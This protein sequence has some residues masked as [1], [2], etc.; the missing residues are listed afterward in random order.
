M[1]LESFYDFY[2]IDQVKIV[3][4]FKYENYISNNTIQTKLY[5]LHKIQKHHPQT[6]FT[7]LINFFKTI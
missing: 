4:N 7:H 5:K 1:N 3:K 2:I 6:F